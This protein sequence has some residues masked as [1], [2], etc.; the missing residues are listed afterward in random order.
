MLGFLPVSLGNWYNSYVIAL[1]HIKREEVSENQYISLVS[2][3]HLIRR[4]ICVS[5]LQKLEFDHTNSLDYVT[6]TH[7]FQP[8]EPCVDV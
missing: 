2:T 7:K 1:V 4:N 3:F 5:A 8:S 6:V